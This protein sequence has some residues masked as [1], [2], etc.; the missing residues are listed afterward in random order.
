MNKENYR[1]I[2]LLSHISKVFERIN[3]LFMK[4]ELSNILT[5]F[6]KGHGA[7]ES[8]FIMIRKWKKALDGNMK[9][10]AIFMDLSKAFDKLNHRIL[11]AKLKAYGLQ[12]TALR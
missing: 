2:S 9:V 5:S 7:Q 3:Q 10:G 4:D 1:S 11:S 8:L 12:P 6:R